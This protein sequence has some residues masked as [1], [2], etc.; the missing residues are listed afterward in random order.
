MMTGAAGTHHQTDWCIAD[1]D[2]GYV[3]P[4][5]TLAMMAIDLLADDGA[6]AQSVLGSFQ[7]ALSKAEYLSRQQAVFK[8]ETFGADTSAG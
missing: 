8:T 1:H 7:P 3:A 5:K 4:A 6:V 2:A